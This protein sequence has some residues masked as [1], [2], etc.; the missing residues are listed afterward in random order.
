MNLKN[1]FGLELG[2]LEK[3]CELNA[4]WILRLLHELSGKSHF[5]SV[6]LSILAYSLTHSS[7]SPAQGAFLVMDFHWFLKCLYHYL[8]VAI[9]TMRKQTYT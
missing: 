7:T 3:T 8:I 6:N 4:W 1:K 2:R 9:S 5:I